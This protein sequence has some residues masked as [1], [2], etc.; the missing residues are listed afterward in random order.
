MQHPFFKPLERLSATGVSKLV[1]YGKKKVTS[2]KLWRSG[3]GTPKSLKDLGTCQSYIQ[4]G[5]DTW[6]LEPSLA[7]LWNVRLLFWIEQPKLESVIGLCSF[8][9]FY[10]ASADISIF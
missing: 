5:G 8:H 7:D 9:D 2:L 3:D 10:D 6:H 1:S 4:V